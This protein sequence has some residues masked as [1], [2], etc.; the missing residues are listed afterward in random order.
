MLACV[1]LAVLV[2]M[3]A[4]ARCVMV[5]RMRLL[6]KPSSWLLHLLLLVV[7]MAAAVAVIAAVACTMLMVHMV[8]LLRSLAWLL[9]AS[10]HRMAVRL[11]VL[12]L[13]LMV[14]VAVLVSAGATAVCMRA[15]C[16]VMR[17]AAV[18]IAAWPA[19]NTSSWCRFFM[20]VAALGIM[21]A[22]C[23]VHVLMV[24]M[25]A[26]A[27]AALG[28]AGAGSNLPLRGA[29]AG[30]TAAAMGMFMVTM[31]AA[32][33]M[34]MSMVMHMDMLH[35]KLRLL[36]YVARRLVAAAAV[37][38]LTSSC[39]SC[40]AAAVVR[41]FMLVRLLVVV[42]LVTA[43]AVLGLRLTAA[44]MHHHQC[45]L[46]L[47]FEDVFHCPSCP[48]HTALL[49]PLCQS[50]QHHQGT[51]LKPVAQ[52]NGTKQGHHHLRRQ[53]CIKPASRLSSS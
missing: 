48:L 15:A 24:V 32:W 45:L 13:L 25:A 8:L 35:S 53:T 30:P 10:P 51:C 18:L 49:Q 33:C 21:V 5:V 29:A 50:E 42:L 39:S 1:A 16:A 11:L 38:M 43:A 52:P 26:V 28:A 47:Q 34:F 12:V 44:V 23:A 14:V 19:V 27:A 4:A 41:V 40:L 6:D 36:P 20:A 2:I 7:V 46:R 31:R 37:R 3:R 17:V 9:V 22:C